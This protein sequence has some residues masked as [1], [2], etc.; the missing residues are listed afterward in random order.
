MVFS[1][2]SIEQLLI[3]EPT[4]DL[5]YASSFP[6]SPSIWVPRLRW[7]SASTVNHGFAAGLGFGV[8]LGIDSRSAERKDPTEP[9]QPTG[10]PTRR[11]EYEN[12]CFLGNIRVWV[13]RHGKTRGLIACEYERAP[14][15]WCSFPGLSFAKSCLLWRRRKAAPKAKTVAAVG[16]MYVNKGNKCS[17]KVHNPKGKVNRKSRFAPDPSYQNLNDQIA[18][19]AKMT[20]KRS[21]IKVANLENNNNALQLRPSGRTFSDCFPTNSQWDFSHFSFLRHWMKTE[22]HESTDSRNRLSD[23]R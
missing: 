13:V 6:L 10:M 3:Q 20:V 21:S 18:A 15:S 4:S 19:L 9:C 5:R 7:S 22:G 8:C 12:E 14:W 23:K 11:Y 17:Q 1:A 2:L 16:M